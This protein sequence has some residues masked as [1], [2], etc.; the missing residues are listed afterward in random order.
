M[1]GPL[2]WQ[3]CLNVSD[4]SQWKTGRKGKLPTP[5]LVCHFCQPWPVDGDVHLSWLCAFLGASP[6]TPSFPSPLCGTHWGKR[7][8]TL[9]AGSCHQFLV[10]FEDHEIAD[11]RHMISAFSLDWK[12]VDT[13]LQCHWNV[14]ICLVVFLSIGSSSGTVYPRRNNL[15]NK[16]IPLSLCCHWSLYFSF[17]SQFGRRAGLHTKLMP[18]RCIFA[19]ALGF[20]CLL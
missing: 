13:Q 5:P 15:I 9:Y 17:I 14:T 20:I 1:C 3:V 7:G 10:P 2:S 16:R 18:T 4:R 19:A 8:L 12:R 11:P 6:F